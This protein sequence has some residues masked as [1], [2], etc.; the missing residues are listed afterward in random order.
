LI[1]IEPAEFTVPTDGA[2]IAS[3]ATHTRVPGIFQ[4]IATYWSIS[5]EIMQYIPPVLS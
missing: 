2:A 5:S 4:D 3:A 1:L